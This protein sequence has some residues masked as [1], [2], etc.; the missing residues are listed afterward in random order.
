[1]LAEVIAT[2]VV[3]HA[4]LMGPYFI[5][6]DVTGYFSSSSGHFSASQWN[7][8]LTGLHQS[9]LS[10]R[11]SLMVES[12]K[13]QLSIYIHPQVFPMGSA[14]NYCESVSGS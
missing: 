2:P 11:C 7:Q 8:S 14:L 1:M 5:C 12:E 3:S 13:I 10:E 4:P 6:T 9:Q